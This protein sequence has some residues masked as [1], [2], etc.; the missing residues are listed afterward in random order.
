MFKLKL[1][2]K[3]KPKPKPKPKLT[4]KLNLSLKHLGPLSVGAALISLTYTLPQFGG[5][6][7]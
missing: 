4:L 7:S 3:L 6:N 2:L 5:E 1:S